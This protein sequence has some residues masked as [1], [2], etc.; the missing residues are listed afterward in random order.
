MPRLPPKTIAVAL[1]AALA[2]SLAAAAR[3]AL[4]EPP[5]LAAACEATPFSGP[6]AVRSAIVQS[7]LEQ[8][9][10]WFALVAALI[11]LLTRRTA[12]AMLA[13]VCAC[14]GLV[15]YSAGPS[16]PAALLAALALI[17]PGAG[18]AA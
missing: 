11:A 14:A 9:I 18:R 16:A 13:L 7:F 3:L 12:I 5:G 4:V 15:L 6:C 17:R 8:R 2:L 10:G 1:V